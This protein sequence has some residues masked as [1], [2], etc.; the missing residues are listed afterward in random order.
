MATTASFGKI[1]EFQVGGAYLERVELNVAANG[2][3]SDKRVA[4]LLSAID[5]RTYALLRSLSSP[6]A[7]ASKSYT[8]LTVLLNSI[9]NRSRW[10]LWNVSGF[11]EETNR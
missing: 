9:T 4:I 3:A 2:V 10:W 11:I 8:Q 5:S 6:V 1:A 7:P